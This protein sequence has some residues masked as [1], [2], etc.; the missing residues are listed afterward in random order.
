MEIRIIGRIYSCMKLLLTESWSL[1]P[2]N[3]MLEILAVF[4]TNDVFVSMLKLDP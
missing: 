4:R 2:K 3:S 1:W